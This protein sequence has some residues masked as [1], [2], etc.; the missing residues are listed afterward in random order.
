MRGDANGDGKVTIADA[1]R[2]KNYLLGTRTLDGD[3]MLAADANSDGQV[4][5]ADAVRI[6]N[7]LLGTKTIEP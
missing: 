3:E 1:V 7:Y 6:K 5:I 2:I 4:S